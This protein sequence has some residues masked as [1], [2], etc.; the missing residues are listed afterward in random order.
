MSYPIA[1]TVENVEACARLGKFVPRVSAWSPVRVVRQTAQVAVLILPQAIKAAV[2][3]GFLARVV[4]SVFLEHAN[5]SLVFLVL[6]SVGT[7]KA[8]APTVEHVEKFAS[9]VNNVL[10]VNA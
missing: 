7:Y 10:A 6:E 9:Q 5:A 2:G 4:S 3:A 8:T 1:N